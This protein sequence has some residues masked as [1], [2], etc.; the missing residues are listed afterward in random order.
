VAR[1]PERA[2]VYVVPLAGGVSPGEGCAT[3]CVLEIEP[4][5]RHTV[6]V[7]SDDYMPAHFELDW[8]S[9]DE[10]IAAGSPQPVD[11]VIPLIQRQSL[12]LKPAPRPAPPRR[13]PP[14]PPPTQPPVYR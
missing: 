3:P 1:G 13:R 7:R 4:F 11:L 8:L 6:T 9:V 10:A 12:E 2:E 5:A 14:K